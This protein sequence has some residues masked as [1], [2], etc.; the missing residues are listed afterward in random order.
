MF[1]RSLS[2]PLQNAS[3]FFSA[4]AGYRRRHRVREGR[5]LHS[6]GHR[7]QPPVFPILS[8]YHRMMRASCRSPRILAGQ[9]RHSGTIVRRCVP[10]RPV[11]WALSNIC[12]TYSKQKW[13]QSSSLA[14]E[15]CTRACFQSTTQGETCTYGDQE[16]PGELWLPEQLEE[17]PG[18]RYLQALGTFGIGGSHLEWGPA[19]SRWISEYR[20]SPDFLDS[21]GKLRRS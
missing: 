10:D 9:S 15:M 14:C 4:L 17:A 5:E 3:Y 11:V 18:I 21:P 16:E 7:T 2:S 12:R 6:S 8:S 13:Q 19:R 1:A 20:R